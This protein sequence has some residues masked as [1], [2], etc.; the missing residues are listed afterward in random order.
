MFVVVLFACVY[1]CVRACVRVTAKSFE[2]DGE[3]LIL[4]AFAKGNCTIFI[5]C[6]SIKRVSKI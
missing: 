5:S 1:V 4:I 3:I 2:P 6:V